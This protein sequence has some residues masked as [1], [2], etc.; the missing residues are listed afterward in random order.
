MSVAV[1]ESHAFCPGEP[2]DLR[3][4]VEYYTGR[5][6]A[7]SGLTAS[8]ADAGEARQALE[9]VLRAQREDFVRTTLA[10]RAPGGGA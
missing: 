8:G 2:S 7:L 9:R 5:L 3:E 4:K 6:L 10:L 1:P